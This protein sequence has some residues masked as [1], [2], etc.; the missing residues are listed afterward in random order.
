VD[1]IRELG[2]VVVGYDLESPV[3]RL[4]GWD[5]PRWIGRGT[6]ILAM[7]RA[8]SAA[9][10]PQRI[11]LGKRWVKDAAGRVDAGCVPARDLTPLGLWQALRARCL[12]EVRRAE[13]ELLR[14][15]RSDAREDPGSI[16]L[17][18]ASERHRLSRAEVA[19]CL[20]GEFSKHPAIHPFSPE[21]LRGPAETPGEQ[22]ATAEEFFAQISQQFDPAERD[23]LRLQLEGNRQDQIAQRV[24]RSVRQVGRTW[25]SVKQ[26]AQEFAPGRLRVPDPVLPLHVRVPDAANEP[27]ATHNEQIKEAA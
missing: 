15:A 12:R 24:G 26:K 14:P 20:V 3:W 9:S 21:P 1:A 23:V 27:A 10:R 22:Q 11:R 2:T 25:N 18:L 13:A 19:L 16:D 17:E 7:D 5:K 4:K 6:A 8:I